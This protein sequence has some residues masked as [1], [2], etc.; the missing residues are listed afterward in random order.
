MYQ[1]RTPEER[2]GQLHTRAAE[3]KRR[4]NGRQLTGL[5]G[6]S[7]FLAIL[8]MTVILQ[9]GGLSQQSTADDQ[10]AGSSLLSESAGGYVLAALIA[11]FAGVILTAVICRHRSK[12]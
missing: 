11:F 9:T 3:L 6:M 12:R 5:A 10:F 4:R 7:A 8:L 1:M 2:I